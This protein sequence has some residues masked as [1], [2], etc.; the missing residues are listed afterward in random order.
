[1]ENKIKVRYNLSKGKNYGKWKIWSKSGV[2]Y[3]S[4][5]IVQL[6][7][8]NC[9]LKNNL[10]IA[11]RIY[12]GENKSVCAWIICESITINHI[13]D[14]DKLESHINIKYNPRIKPNWDINGLNGDNMFIKKI[15][16]NDKKLYVL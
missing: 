6:I 11:Q 10:K 16:T 1:M 2:E 7:L 4:P 12:E 8:N 3:H 9:Q 15:F 13:G 5:E 14:F